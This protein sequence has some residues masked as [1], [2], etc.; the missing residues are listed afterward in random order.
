MISKF[1][2]YSFTF[3]LLVV[4]VTLLALSR[5]MPSNPGR[6]CAVGRDSSWSAPE[7][8]SKSGESLVQKM[9][10]AVA[11]AGPCIAQ[12]ERPPQMQMM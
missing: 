7:G 2:S 1:I 8:A 6:R 3:V 12:E 5:Y 10:C 4:H 9:L 11:L